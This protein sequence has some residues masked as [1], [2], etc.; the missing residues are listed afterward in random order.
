MGVSYALG[1]L[2]SIDDL[3]WCASRVGPEDSV[4]VPETWGM[5]CFSVMAEVAH[6]SECRTIGS[7]ILNVYS[8][9]P[10]AMA[11][12]AATVDTLSGGRLILG[13]GAS[14][15]AIVEGFHGYAYDRPLQRVRECV[16]IVRLALGGGRIDYDGQLFKLRG[17]SLLI[18]PP[19]TSIPI[20]LAAVNPRMVNLA[21]EVADGV[22]FYLRPPGEMG[23]TI[24]RMQQRRRIRTACPVITAVSEDAERAYERARRTLAFYVSVARVYREFLAG[25][26]FARETSMIYGQYKKSGLADAHQAVSDHMLRS[27]TICGTPQECLSGLES[28]RE[29]GVDEPIIQFNPVGDVRESFKLLAGMFS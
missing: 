14:S 6:R 1:S 8:R 7:S 25:N 4:W 5:D 17:F 12:G 19:R 3:L 28:L 23:E 11:M 16:Q 29:T 24:R 21:W 10:S 15:P 20:Y 27:L 22:I 2:L 9:S 13:I 26:G 18:K